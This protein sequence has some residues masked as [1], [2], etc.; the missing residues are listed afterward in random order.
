[1]IENVYADSENRN[2][3]LLRLNKQT[4]LFIA[5][6][7][8]VYQKN[9]VWCVKS[10]DI[11]NRELC[12]NIVQSVRAMRDKIVYPKEVYNGEKVAINETFRD[13]PMEYGTA[14][15]K[16]FIAN[17]SKILKNSKNELSIGNK[18]TSLF[19]LLESNKDKLIK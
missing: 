12:G 16:G 7:V 5:D 18:Q 8:M 6:K 4:S 13:L 9:G 3:Y 1:M 11:V 19:S 2:I 15:P 10:L 14:K 17:T